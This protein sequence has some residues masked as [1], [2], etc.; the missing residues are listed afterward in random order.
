MGW[1][2]N[3]K[4]AVGILAIVGVCE[5]I[6]LACTIGFAAAID[7]EHNSI[8]SLILLVVA[9]LF[10]SAI[11]IVAFGSIK[12]SWIRDNLCIKCIVVMLLM[13]LGSL[14]HF[15]AAVLMTVTTT[16]QTERGHRAFGGFIAGLDF[17]ITILQFVFCISISFAI[18]RQ[19][20]KDKENTQAF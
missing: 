17:I 6:A 4:V 9:I 3:T 15:T 16:E 2:A 1:K 8:K 7:E 13:F 18:F 11:A 5:A 14:L 10:Q 12:A 19:H 20:D